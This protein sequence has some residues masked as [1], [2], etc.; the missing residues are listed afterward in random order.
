MSE[1]A[2]ARAYAEIDRLKDRLAFCTEADARSELAQVK[3]ELA[4]MHRS[5]DQ[6]EEDCDEYEAER[7]TAIRELEA[8]RDT[9][10]TLNP[11]WAQDR[12]RAFLLSMREKADTDAR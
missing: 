8:I 1:S 4:A 12:A 2:V 11:G 10:F 6:L 3:A 7:D 9:P 5:R